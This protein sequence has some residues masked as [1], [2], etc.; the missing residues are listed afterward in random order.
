M[1][2]RRRE[3]SL[4]VDAE[5]P[6]IGLASFT[7]ASRS[8]FHGR[9]DEITELCRRIQRK[10]LT[11][12]FGKS[13][14]GKTSILQA[15]V[16]PR[17]RDQGY[18]PVYLRIDYAAGA[19]S[20][21]EQI[22]QAI[23]KAAEQSGRWTR[24]DVADEGE[25]LWA[26]LHHRDDVLLDAEG[27]PL[28]PLLI[29][30]QFEEIFTLAQADEQGRERAAAFTASLAD[31]VEN[32]PPAELEALLER[33]D[34]AYERYDLARA[35]YRVV[36]SLREDYLAHL[37]GLKAAMP[38]ITQN[39]LRLAPMTGTQALAAVI[40]PGRHLVNDEVAAA[41]VR[42][43]AGGSEVAHAEVEPS[44]LSLI[45]RELND[46][47]I[48]LG[49]P[50]IGADLLAGSHTTILGEFYE[51]SV[52]DQPAGVRTFIEDHL[53]TDSGY[54]E[55]VAE[56]RVRSEFAAAGAA[57]DAL[58]SLVNRRL[59]RIEERLDLRR[60]ELTHDVLCAVV[61]ASRDA[62][63]ERE[64]LEASTRLLAEQAERARLDQRALARARAVASGCVLLAAGAIAAS[65]YA[66]FNYRQA[67]QAEVAAQATRARAEHLVGY[68]Q[69]DFARELEPVAHFDLMQG[70]NDRVVGYFNSLPADQRTSESERN[71]AVA[72]VK[73]AGSLDLQGHVKEAIGPLAVALPILE[74]RFA[75]GQASEST[76]AD[77]AYALAMKGD[78]LLDR[79]GDLA[80]GLDLFKRA[81]AVL[82]STIA[83]GKGSK[84]TRLTYAYGT[85]LMCDAQSNGNRQDRA[86][87]LATCSAA[88][89][90]ASDLGAMD[91]SDSKV[92]QRY[93]WVSWP[94]TKL[95]GGQGHSQQAL[96][97]GEPA[98]ALG[99]RLVARYPEYSSARLL[100][101]LLTVAMG[102]VHLQRLELRQALEFYG[103]AESDLSRLA[104]ADPGN[105]Y[106]GS[107]AAVAHA[108]RAEVAL[109]QGDPDMALARYREAGAMVDPTRKIPV[110]FLVELIGFRSASAIID[111]DR[112]D[113]SAVDMMVTDEK[114]RLAEFKLLPTP[115]ARST[116]DL[117]D[118]NDDLMQASVAWS[119]GDDVRSRDI[120][121]ARL[122]YIDAHP[123]KEDDLDQASC[124]SRLSHVLAKALY[125]AGDAV[126]AEASLHK[127][128]LVFNAQADN[129]NTSL[130]YAAELATWLALAQIRQG[131]VVDAKA[132]LVPVLAL[133]RRLS[134]S[135][136][137]SARQHLELA[138]ALYAQSLTESGRR[139]QVLLSEATLLVDHLPATMRRLRSVQMWQGWISS[140]RLS[141]HDRVGAADPSA[142]FERQAAPTAARRSASLASGPRS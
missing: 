58:A 53:L 71:R 8:Y 11:V 73:Q 46:Q 40:E 100:L 15:G 41:I 137:E 43:V 18:C 44:L 140:A 21:E 12:L 79:G 89:K 17:L 33:D 16:V 78:L 50:E 115:A 138:A 63:R 45:C 141:T 37:E 22:K 104:K 102:D 130:R 98:I 24:A 59:L 96:A 75:N 114:R 47:R 29:F 101:S 82:H 95:L 112:G 39:R 119:G 132:T 131:H 36:I 20:A 34:S 139:R 56:E 5:H 133:Q 99:R 134:G 1:M 108:R 106:V 64:A 126:G 25:S 116:V 60:V 128:I 92:S 113:Q 51:R 2:A 136:P 97:E 94:I 6:W 77:L 10:P 127:A 66:L 26:F 3:E 110:F 7:E 55:N 32:R 19:P 54:R 76:R 48:A 27:R 70:L 57:P 9:D 129:S 30:D 83:A 90:I 105:T 123:E 69:N 121:L 72:L 125:R 86:D 88:R 65:G 49:R 81:E 4:S 42:F 52:G 122:A 117:A 31:L 120:A 23:V 103:D 85:T 13:G 61:R 107:N 142:S 67:Q 118:C 124:H 38:S 135:S 28:L 93:V 35:D 80:D 91:L 109:E 84:D 68:L 62:R 14:L 74:A 111:A 87:A